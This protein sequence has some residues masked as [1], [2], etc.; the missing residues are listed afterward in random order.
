MVQ[1]ASGGRVPKYPMRRRHRGRH[2]AIEQDWKSARV[3]WV[4]HTAKP[5]LA[6]SGPSAISAAHS[7]RGI[8]ARQLMR[9]RH[10]TPL[11]MALA[12]GA[13]AAMAQPQLPEGPGKAVIEQSCL[14]CHEP[15]RI[16]NSGYNRQDWQ[17]V[18]HMMLNVGA[19]VPPDQ[20]ARAD[21]LSGEE[22]PGE[23]EARAVADRRRHAR[24]DQGMGGA[25]AGFA[26]ARSARLSGRVDLVHRPNGERARP[27]RSAQREVHRV[28]PRHAVVRAARAGRRPGRQH[29]VHRQLRRLYRQ[30]RSED[31]QVHRL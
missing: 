11:A 6:A 24:R 4:E 5:E 16:V 28:S 17:N 21:R 1:P 12:C 8:R 7:A 19:P 26:A 20:V 14:G 27:A 30:A 29:L 13:P 9:T 25:D 23:A 2:R 10:L 15:T 22:L 18:V 31:R 3:R